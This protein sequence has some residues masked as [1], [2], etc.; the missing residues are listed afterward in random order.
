MIGQGFIAPFTYIAPDAEIDLSG[1]RTLG[2]DFIASDLAAAVDRTVSPETSSSIS[3]STYPAAPRFV[4]A[5]LWRT[6]STSQRNS[7][8]TA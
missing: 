1:V 2:G 6:P 5:S 7:A 3:A 8:P 4:F